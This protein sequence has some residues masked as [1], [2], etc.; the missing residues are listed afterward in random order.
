MTHDLL[1]QIFHTANGTAIRLTC[2]END[3]ALEFCIENLAYRQQ[4]NRQIKRI[5]LQIVCYAFVVTYLLP[6][7]ILV[8]V[9]F[10]AIVCLQIHSLLNLV[11]VGELSDR[12]FKLLQFN[13]TKNTINYNNFD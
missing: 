11:C 10:V 1:P 5:L 13:C 9:G 6:Y 8:I 7:S 12:Y 3:S 2:K 4:R